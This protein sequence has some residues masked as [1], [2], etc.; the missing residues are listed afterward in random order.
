MIRTNHKKISHA[1]KKK[2]WQDKHIVKI[3]NLLKK[4]E[5]NKDK[6][7]KVLDE[8]LH[9]ILFFF[10]IIGN[11]FVIFSMLPLI[12]GNSQWVLLLVISVVGLCFGFLVDHLLRDLD[13]S[14]KHYLSAGIV[15][16]II[17]LIIMLIV[18]ELSKNVASRLNYVIKI[19]PI[20]SVVVYI[21][22]FSSPHLV[23]KIKEH[24]K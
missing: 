7:T 15:L 13:I 4:G 2:G 10:V 17:S 18:F 6:K 20:L 1:L 9:I 3:S 14:K 24:K 16:P 12:L 23:Y 21:I 8:F 22:A 11:V 19:N 5:K